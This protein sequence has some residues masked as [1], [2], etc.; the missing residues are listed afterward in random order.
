M[1]LSRRLRPAKWEYWRVILALAGKDIVDAIKNRTS[2]MI[3][4]GLGLMILTVQALPLM[5]KM[6]DRPRV[7]IYDADRSGLADQLRLDGSLQVFEMRTA[8]EAQDMAPEASSP[9]LALTLPDGWQSASGP[10]QLQG[11][12]AYWIKPGAAS[13][14]V[15]AAESALTAATGRQ[16]VIQPQMVYPTPENRGHLLMLASGLVLATVLTTAILVPHLILE[17]KTS[18]TLELLRVSPVSASQLLIGKGLA[19]LVYG[20]LA[21]AV[22]LAFNLGMVN[23]WGLMLP[24]LLGAILFGVGLGLLAGI[25]ASNEGTM[26]MWIGL[27]AFLLMFSTLVSFV[28]LSR[29][30]EWVQQIL[31]WL[32]TTAAFELIRISFGNT[33]PAALIWPRLLVLLAAVLLVFGAA[34]WRLRA[35]EA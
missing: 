18:H 34:G 10:L 28:N 29:L 32:P 9:L 33:F 22:L 13:Q 2:L 15:S 14:M 16:V 8:E 31:A 5:L 24:A 30:P 23:Q 6:D 35:W 4:V 12:L 7:A 11:N 27:L 25:L 3:L 19:G 26:Q 17:E 21:G 1:E 20:A